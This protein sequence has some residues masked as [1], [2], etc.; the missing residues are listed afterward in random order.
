MGTS[1]SS[2][3]SDRFDP[4]LL[5]RSFDAVDHKLLEADFFL[6]ALFREPLSPV[7]ASFYL[8]A[9]VSAARSVTFALQAVMKDAPSFSS[10]YDGRRAQLGANPIARWFVTTR[11]LNQKLGLAP[12]RSGS[13]IDGRLSYQFGNDGD[14]P[15]A[16]ERDV[17]KASRVPS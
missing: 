16:P 11:N 7:A 14:M 9:F 8:S 12:I 17:E 5:K 1:A 6:E 13:L 2:G 4:R 15:P 3:S 10:W